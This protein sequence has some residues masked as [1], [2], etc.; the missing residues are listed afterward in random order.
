MKISKIL[1]GGTLT[2]L[3]AA[4]AV[5][6]APFANAIGGDGKPPIPA[7]TCRAI[8]SAA[9]AGEPVPDPSILHDSDS[10]PAYLKDGR[11]DF[12]VQKDFPYRKELDAAVAEWNEALK[13]KVV[14]AETATA[15]DQTI[16]VRYDPVPDSYVLAQASPSHRYLSVHVTSYLYPDAI[17][18]TIA[19]EFGHL[20][21]IRHT[22]DHTLMA[23]SMHRHPSAHVTATDVASVLQGQFD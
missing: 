15:T 4:S 20:L 2:T 6:T 11:L 22:C 1:T 14:L 3:A 18:A 23:G 12:V 7:A 21:G 17:R 9:N 10:I 16:S 5:V 13:G 8:V 19:H